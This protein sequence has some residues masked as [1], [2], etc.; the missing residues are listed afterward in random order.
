MDNSINPISD[1]FLEAKQSF[2]SPCTC[3]YLFI[4]SKDLQNL[5]KFNS[6]IELRIDN[7][8]GFARYIHRKATT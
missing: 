2:S 7:L 3:A 6:L 1:L 5:I 4:A 8:T